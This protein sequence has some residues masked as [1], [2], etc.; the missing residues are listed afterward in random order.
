MKMVQTLL[1]LVL[2]L[3]LGV[4]SIEAQ[5]CERCGQF[6]CPAGEHKFVSTGTPTHENPHSNCAYPLWG[7]CNNHPF[8]GGEE[9]EEEASLFVLFDAALARDYQGMVAPS[10]VL[11]DRL[12]VNNQRSS[13]QLLS[14]DSDNAVVANLPM[15]AQL[16]S[17]LEGLLE[18]R[19][20]WAAMLGSS[21]IPG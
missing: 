19:R 6:D 5:D 10:V 12:T 7:F 13:I 4:T 18:S 14:C 8:C 11:F 2:G 9:E 3:F 20:A 15:P 21:R 16:L 1:L 17:E